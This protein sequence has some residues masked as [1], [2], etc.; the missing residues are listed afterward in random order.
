MNK[1]PTFIHV[2]FVVAKNQIAKKRE[3]GR[4]N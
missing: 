4:E 2:P 1:S 3:G